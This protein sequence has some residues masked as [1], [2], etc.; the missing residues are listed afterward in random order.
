MSKFIGLGIALLVLVGGAPALAASATTPS[1]LVQTFDVEQSP[2]KPGASAHFLLTM[3]LQRADGS[4]AAATTRVN[5]HILKTWR[6]NW[7]KFPKCD[8]A[9]LQLRGVDGCPKGSQVGTGSA[10]AD[11]A[12]LV[13]D[14]VEGEVTAFNGKRIDGKRTFLIYTVPKV[15]SPVLVT[16]TETRKHFIEF[17]I[18]LIPTLPGRANAVL[19][20]FFLR[21]GGEVTKTK[22][23]NGRD[24]R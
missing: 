15:G 8:P 17:P 10:K 16:G 14:P 4:R 20:Y 12:P 7:A 1:G 9:K 23:V 6:W 24:G 11:A 21:A 22:R 13:T 3:A 19:T 5:A 2:S 18:P